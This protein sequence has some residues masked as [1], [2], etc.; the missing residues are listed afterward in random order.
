MDA[1]GYVILRGAV[2]PD[3][4]QA[5]ADLL[6]AHVGASPDDPE[7]WSRVRGQ[8]GIMI[9]LFQGAAFGA[10]RNSHRVHKA[11]AQ[12]WGT[13]DLWTIVDRMSFNPPVTPSRRFQGPRLHWD[14]SLVQPIPFATQGILY[15]TDTAPDQGAL[16]LVPGFHRRIDAWLE[17]LGGDAD[18]RQADLSAEGVTIGAGAGDLVIWRN[19][20]P[21]GA[22]PNTAARPRL[23]HYLTM[24]SPEMA[25]VDEW[26]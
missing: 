18:P 24:Y 23:A 17:A 20:L 2:S 4:A 14:V 7:S 9:Q 6:Y 22:S 15:L 3:E 10:L 25:I 21:H 12:L 13:A 5:A 19:T 16:E 26:R 11:F 8:N 1:Q